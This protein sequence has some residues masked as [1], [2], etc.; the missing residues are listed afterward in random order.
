MITAI[1]TLEGY[2]VTENG[3]RRAVINWIDKKGKECEPRKAVLCVV[4]DDDEFVTIDLRELEDAFGNW[5][6]LRRDGDKIET[7]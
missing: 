4:A 3:K 6:R 5:K 7:A 2:A 1:N